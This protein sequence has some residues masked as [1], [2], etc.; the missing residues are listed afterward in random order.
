[1]SGPATFLAK[2]IFDGERLHRDAAIRFGPDGVAEVGPHTA[3]ADIE[4]AIDLG[5]DLVSLGFVDLQVNGGGGVMLNDHPTIKTVRR[6]ADA[7]WSLGVRRLLPTLITDSREN[8]QA[9]IDAVAK[10]VASGV[11]CVA[12]LHLEGPHLSVVRK[13]A[14]DAAHIRPMEQRDLDLLLSAAERLP[15]LMVTVAP[16]SV[17][18]EQV[19]A[20]SK[21][22]VIVS[23]GH[24]DA[25]FA[26]CLDYAA[27][28]A[29]CV[30]HLFNAMSQMGSRE[31]GL[32][33]AAI[34]S[35][36]LSAGLIADGVHVH[37]Q[38]MR[39]AWKSKQRPGSIFLVSDAMAVAGTDLHAFSLGGRN[40]SRANGR[41]VLDDGTLAGADLDLVSAVRNMV[42]TVGIDLPDALRAATAVP[43]EMITG[44]K[45]EFVGTKPSDFIRIDKDLRT[46]RPLTQT[47]HT[48]E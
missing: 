20:L 17:T 31:P 42:E 46:V 29:R 8:T 16:E 1:M 39:I 6:I 5:D 41:L 18:C 43:L 22:G 4:N 40:V 38:T 47:D 32:V 15:V 2:S 7:H 23:L 11:P 37:P 25:D 3:V 21:A 13:G 10:A 44:A 28:G 26:T 27:A 30:T 9:A 34:A 36:D 19:S 45:F 12:G 33:G 24:T 48:G 14:H 35:G